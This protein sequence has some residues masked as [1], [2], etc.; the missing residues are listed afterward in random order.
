MFEGFSQETLDFMWGIRFNN[1]RSWFEAHKQDYLEHLYRP[2]KALCAQVYEGLEEDCAQRGMIG[3]VCRIY[4]DARRLHGRGPYKDHL[5]FS[6]EQPT[7]RFAAH[8]TFWFELDPDGWSYGLGYYA[9]RP[10]TMAKLRA[11]MDRDPA[12]S[13][14][15][16]I[17]VEENGEFLLDGPAYKKE[18]TA[19]IPQLTQWYNKKS[20]SFHHS[21]PLTEEIYSPGLADRL[22]SGLH[23]LFPLHDYLVT[24]DSDPPPAEYQNS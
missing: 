10:I 20:F 7:E 3:R 21:E 19:P 17:Q 4:R 11:R 12:P 8:P 13:L 5:W 24:L 6:I 14:A 9:A 2:M 15:L 22:V 16:L 23:T 1:E 18:K